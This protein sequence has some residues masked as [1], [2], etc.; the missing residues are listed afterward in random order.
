MLGDE[1][2][3]KIV[4]CNIIGVASFDE[5]V[6]EV[7]GICVGREIFVVLGDLFGDCRGDFEVST[8]WTA[9]VL[10]PVGGGYEHSVNHID[11]F[12]SAGG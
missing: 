4:G 7:I 5:P 12:L 9:E 8:M 10:G 11:E 3:A 2:S 1:M 6:V